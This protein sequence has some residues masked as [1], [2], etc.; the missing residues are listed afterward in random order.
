MLFFYAVQYHLLSVCF[1]L[2]CLILFDLNVLCFPPFLVLV[3]L[4]PARS[5]LGRDPDSGVS[6]GYPAS[7]GGPGGTGSAVHRFPPYLF[8][9][10]PVYVLG[11]FLVRACG[12]GF[13]LCRF[14]RLRSI[15]TKFVRV[16]SLACDTLRDL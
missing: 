6:L 16:P 14:L 10:S 15:I 9:C 12:P 11:L 7:L 2:V 5:V 8:T 1:F 13:R 3:L 4:F